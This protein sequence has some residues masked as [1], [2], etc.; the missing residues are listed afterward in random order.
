MVSLVYDEKTLPTIDPE[1]GPY[2]PFLKNFDRIK[3]QI[4]EQ[5]NTPDGKTKK[6]RTR[7]YNE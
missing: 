7:S 5:L 1:E 4:V 6:S 2:S 3:H